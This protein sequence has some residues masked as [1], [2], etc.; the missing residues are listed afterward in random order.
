MLKEFFYKNLFIIQNM[1]RDK[2]IAIILANIYGIRYD[3][4]NEKFAKKYIKFLKSN[5]NTLLN[6]NKYKILMIEL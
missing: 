1:L 5:Y 3:F 4:I 2:I 6:Q